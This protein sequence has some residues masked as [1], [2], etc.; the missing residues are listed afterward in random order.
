MKKQGDE[1]ERI[2]KLQKRLMELNY[3]NFLCCKIDEPQYHLS[4]VYVDTDYEY[5]QYNSV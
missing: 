2:Q 1:N 5:S 4:L 3:L